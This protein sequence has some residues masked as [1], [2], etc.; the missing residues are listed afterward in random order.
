MN[1]KPCSRTW[2]CTWRSLLRIRAL[3]SS[4]DYPRRCVCYDNTLPLCQQ[5]A[6][7]RFVRF[8]RRGSPPDVC[9]R[10]DDVGPRARNASTASDAISS[11]AASTPHPVL[12][13][14]S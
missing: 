7:L 12:A 10:P 9:T 4:S 6:D 8:A 3:R 2:S 14:V 5:Q 11:N 1:E 13:D